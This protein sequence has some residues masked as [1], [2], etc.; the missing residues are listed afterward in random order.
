MGPSSHNKQQRI[1]ASHKE[2]RVSS[3]SR[4]APGFTSQGIA[5]ENAAKAAK[6]AA[7][8]RSVPAAWEK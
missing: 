2:L 1:L 7:T 8:N 6:A 4:P 5:R 3:K